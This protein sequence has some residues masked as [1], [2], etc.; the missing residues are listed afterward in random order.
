MKLETLQ[1]AIGSFKR[2]EKI[3]FLRKS[4]DCL[5]L[6]KPVWVSINIAWTKRSPPSL[7]FEQEI[8]IA[9]LYHPP[10]LHNPSGK[11]LRPVHDVCLITWYCSYGVHIT[12]FLKLILIHFIPPL[13]PYAIP[14]SNVF[15]VK[16]LG[17]GLFNHCIQH[18]WPKTQPFPIVI[19]QIRM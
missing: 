11:K 3:I 2:V 18:G 1:S 17:W 12:S 14:L 8:V 4:N 5:K 9:C 16:I 6:T 10:M 15:E 7:N 19:F 13:S